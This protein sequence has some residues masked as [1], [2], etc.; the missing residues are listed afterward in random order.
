[1]NTSLQASLLWHRSLTP[2][3]FLGKRLD[4]RHGVCELRLNVSCCWRLRGHF[5]GTLEQNGFPTL[6]FSKAL[7]ASCHVPSV[8]GAT[9]VSVRCSSCADPFHTTSANQEA[10][11]WRLHRRQICPGEASTREGA[12]PRS[13]AETY[14]FTG[15]DIERHGAS[16]DSHFH[17]LGGRVV[18]DIVTALNV[19][20]LFPIISVELA[21]SKMIYKTAP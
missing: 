21:A 12:S 14:D 11:I 16:T 1:M 2:L 18:Y 10:E 19:A 5:T 6:H 7:A 20:V 9:R 8:S 3:T 15:A 4:D 13:E 17:R